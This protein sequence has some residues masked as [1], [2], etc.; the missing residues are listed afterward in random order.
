VAASV[1]GGAFTVDSQGVYWLPSEYGNVTSQ[2]LD[3]GPPV[4][5]AMNQLADNIAVD[6]TSVYWTA[7]TGSSSGAIVK[8]SKAGGTPVTLAT[9]DTEAYGIAVDATNVYWVTVGEGVFSIPTAGGAVATLASL[10]IASVQIALDDTSIYFASLTATDDQILDSIPKSGG[11]PATL[12]GTDGAV[13]I[14]VDD[15]NVYWGT[16]SSEILSMPKTGGTATVIATDDVTGFYIAVDATNVYWTGN[17]VHAAP[18]TGGTSS[19]LF[20]N[21]EDFLTFVAAAN[22]KVYWLSS[23]SGFLDGGPSLVNSISATSP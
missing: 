13:S 21:D 2:P 16:L 19:L 6:D 12:A 17:A 3:G 18:K 1:G 23:V 9:T 4:A 10:D 8:S 7:I 22:S 5:L 11:T 20:F 15:T 14:A